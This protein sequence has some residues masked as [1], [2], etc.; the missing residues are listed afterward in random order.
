MTAYRFLLK[1]GSNH[2]CP[3]KSGLYV[4]GNN[5]ISY[6]T[7]HFSIVYLCFITS[8]LPLP[9]RF[10]RLFKRTVIGIRTHY[11]SY[12]NRNPW[13]HHGWAVFSNSEPQPDSGIG[14]SFR[15]VRGAAFHTRSSSSWRGRPEEAGSQEVGAQSF[16]P[17]QRYP[18]VWQHRHEQ[19]LVQ[20]PEGPPFE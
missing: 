17:L 3:N 20:E 4:I 14:E 7:L 18:C 6:T 5:Q 13:W 15:A 16:P 8:L 2:Q 1:S 19:P 11:S 12:C 9:G 10:H